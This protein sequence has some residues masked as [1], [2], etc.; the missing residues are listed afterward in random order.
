MEV[1]GRAIRLKNVLSTNA[2]VAAAAEMVDLYYL[3]V[4][5]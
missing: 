2:R 5:P 3:S 1:T 4:G